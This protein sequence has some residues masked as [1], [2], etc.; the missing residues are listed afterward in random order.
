[1]VSAL[2]DPGG[3]VGAAAGALQLISEVVGEDLSPDEDLQLDSDVSAIVAQLESRDEDLDQRDIAP[4][5][6]QP[7]TQGVG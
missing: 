7:V 6:P 5:Q 1:V 4:A 2:G 3:A